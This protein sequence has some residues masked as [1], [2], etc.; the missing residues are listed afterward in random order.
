MELIEAERALQRAQRD[1]DVAALDALLHPRCVGVFL[2]GSI[3]GKADDLEGHRSGSMRITKL[4][5]EEMTAE[6]NGPVGVTRTVAWVE[7]L[8][9]GKPSS[10]RLRYTRLWSREGG[11]WRVV[12]ATLAAITAT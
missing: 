9:G 11:A 10:A 8:V 5:E 4:V 6:E 7:A 2:D 3:F 12:A 1:A